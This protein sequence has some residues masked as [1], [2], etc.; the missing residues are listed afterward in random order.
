MKPSESPSVVSAELRRRAEERLRRQAPVVGAA[1]TEE[2]IARLLHELQTHQIELELQNEEL[3]EAHAKMETIL[4]QYTDLYDFAPTSYLSLAHDGAILTVNLTGARLLGLERSRL[5][6]RRFGVFVASRDRHDFND[7]LREVFGGKA[8]ASCEV[9]LPQAGSQPRFVRVQGTPTAD[10][11]ECRAVVFDRTEHKRAEEALRES[12]SALQAILQAAADGILAANNEGRARY[13]ND[14]FAELWR[15]SPAL[16]SSKDEAKMLQHVLDQLVDPQGFLQTVQELCRSQATSF[17]TLYFKD[18]RVFERLSH[19]LMQGTT[20]CGRVW[21]FRDVTERRRFEGEREKLEAQNRRLQKSES[22]SRMAGA[23]AHTFNNQLQAAMMNLEFAMEQMPRDG[24]LIEPL[25]A[26]MGA[27]RK[28]AEVSTLML[29][30]VGQTSAKRAP[31]DLSE[32]CQRSVALLR[33]G[34]PNSVV[35]ATDLPAPG[36]SIQANANQIQ[37]VLTN[38]LANAW[39]ACGD[40]G[41]SIHLQVKEVSAAEIPAA[42]R[43]PVGSRLPDKTYACVTL[44]DTGCGISEPDIEKIFDPFFSTKFTGRGIGLAVVL[45]ILRGHCGV[46][47]VESK[48]GAGTV[49]RVFLPISPEAVL[50]KPIPV[51]VL[52]KQALRGTVLVVDDEPL[53]CLTVASVLRRAGFT[54]LTARDGLEAVEVFRAQPEEIRLVLCD[55][56]MPRMGGWETLEALRKL[57]PGI[58]V[59]LASGYSEAQVMAGAHAELPQAILGKPYALATLMSAFSEALENEKKS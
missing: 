47:T 11:K 58:P 55:L 2:E 45:G 23:I 40:R 44:A 43:F 57:A 38:L 5:V 1:Q 9:T 13:A 16:L 3:L 30:Y 20:L 56:T 34:M 50:P 4:T 19:P 48:A 26:A 39:E 25:S 15:I 29:T 24:G 6:G 12:E 35:L 36:P 54:V 52:P 22:L 53:V 51:A 31:V 18:G 27:L 37:Q 32:V 59:I 17:D 33:A 7:F 49:F 10:G 41:G 42:N 21:S 46:V 28:A 14:R 8:G